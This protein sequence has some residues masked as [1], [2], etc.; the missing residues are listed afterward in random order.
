MLEQQE[1]SSEAKKSMDTEKMTQLEGIRYKVF[2]D[3]YSLKDPSG[4]PLEYYPEQ[5]WARVAR[6]IASVEPS[7]ELQARWE[8]RFYEALSDFQFVPGGRILAGA[9]SGHALQLF[10]NTKPRRQPPWYPRQPQTHDRDHGARG[11]SGHQPFDA[12]PAWLVH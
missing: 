3:R 2:M 1:Q 9:G 12:A 6:G 10:R 4:K 11:R 5:L 8:K 7:E